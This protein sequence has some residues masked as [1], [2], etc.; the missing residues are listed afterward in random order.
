VL[1]I[2]DSISMG[3]TLPVRATL[4]GKANIHH[5]PE[6]CSSA[7]HGLDR[8]DQWL[9]QEHWDVIFSALFSSRGCFFC[10]SPARSADK[11]FL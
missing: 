7:S 3:Y 8:L 6:N 4:T 9:G 2:G 5:P 11:V 1:L 10:C